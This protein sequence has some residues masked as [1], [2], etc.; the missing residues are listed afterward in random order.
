[1]NTKTDDKW[2]NVSKTRPFRDLDIITFENDRITYSVLENVENQINLKEKEVENSSK[3]IADLNFEF[4]DS[5]RIRFYLK[6]K[7]ITMFN[8]T[9]SKTEGTIFEQDYVRL[10]PTVSKISESR[11]QL[12]KYNFKWNNEQEIIEFNKILDQPKMIKTLSKMRYSGRKILLEKIDHT[13][14]ISSFY[15]NRK[16]L[17]LLIKEIDETKAVLYGLPQEP[18]EIVVKRID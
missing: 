15:N 2:I 1:M 9:E 17:V 3:K 6:G 11:I 4:I 18:F 13:L 8:K 10:T 14:L 16:G 12:L 5:D 7:I